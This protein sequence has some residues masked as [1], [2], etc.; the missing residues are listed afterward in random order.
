MCLSFIPTAE[1]FVYRNRAVTTATASLT[2]NER[3]LSK[4][5][6]QAQQL[7]PAVTRLPAT[8][9]CVKMRQEQQLMPA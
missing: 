5:S 6:G 7:L 2:T 8:E 9:F 1:K 4:K 3:N